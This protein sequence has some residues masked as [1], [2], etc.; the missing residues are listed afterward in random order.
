MIQGA[1]IHEQGI[2]FGIIVVQLWVLRNSVEVV[3]H[4]ALGKRVLGPIPIVLVA[5]DALGVPNFLGRHDL[6]QFLVQTPWPQIHAVLKF[7]P[8]PAAP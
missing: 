1:L 2:T 8:L 5:Q 3:R 6:V 4:Q 7:F